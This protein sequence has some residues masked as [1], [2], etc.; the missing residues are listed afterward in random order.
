MLPRATRA[1]PIVVRGDPRVATQ[2]V[3]QAVRTFASKYRYGGGASFEKL[4]VADYANRR[5]SSG[6]ML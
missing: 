2:A 4:E 1:A 3:L 5:S 6:Q